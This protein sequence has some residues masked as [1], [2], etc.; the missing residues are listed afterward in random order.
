MSVV[1]TVLNDLGLYIPDWDHIVRY[2]HHIV[3]P[4]VPST[5]LLDTVDATVTT[6]VVGD[7]VDT[8]MTPQLAQPPTNATPVTTTMV[9]N[10]TIPNNM[11]SAVAC[12]EP[13][14]VDGQIVA[15]VTQRHRAQK[16]FSEAEYSRMSNDSLVQLILRRDADLKAAH[17][18]VAQLDKR[19]PRRQTGDDALVAPD[20]STAI[21]DLNKPFLFDRRGTKQLSVRGMFAVALRR[22]FGNVAAHHFGSNVSPV[23]DLGVYT[24]NQYYIHRFTL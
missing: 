8:Y 22:N 24:I 2:L 3:A 6:G 13:Q 19:Q 10:T 5:L 17:L 15:V 20:A 12:A 4:R 1:I 9:A 21:V 23:I 14:P 18:R 16:Y 7:D 11:G